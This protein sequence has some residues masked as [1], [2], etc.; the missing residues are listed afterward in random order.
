MSRFVDTSTALMSI[1]TGLRIFV[2]DLIVALSRMDC[3]AAF[4]LLLFSFLWQ[5]Q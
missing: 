2:F 1:S 5:W 3:K 4:S